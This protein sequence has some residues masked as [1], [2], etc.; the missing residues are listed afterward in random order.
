MY[1]PQTRVILALV[2]G[3]I[4][5]TTAALHAKKQYC[6][7]PRKDGVNVTCHLYAVSFIYGQTHRREVE[8]AKRFAEKYGFKH[9]VISIGSLSAKNLGLAYG[10]SALTGDKPIPEAATPG[11]VPETYVPQRN[12]ILLAHAAAILEILLDIHNAYLGVL[13]VGFHA[14]DNAPG[15]PVYPDTRKEFVNA[16]ELAVN[17]GSGRVYEGRSRIVVHAPWVELPKWKI[18]V[19]GIENGMDYSITWTCY[20][21]GEKP[22]G[23]CPSCLHRLRSFVAAGIPDPL[24]QHYEHLPKWYKLWLN[25]KRMCEKGDVEACKRA[26]NATAMA[27]RGEIPYPTPSQ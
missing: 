16:I 7:L 27:R 15:E 1:R 22:C 10:G 19:W 11:R 20:R 26:E 5:S 14:E 8:A 21:G 23:R 6:D 4:D 13:V 25:D 24:T 17:I 9:L 3:G 18:I 12:M 2:S